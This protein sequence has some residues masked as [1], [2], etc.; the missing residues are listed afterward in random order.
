MYR[1]VDTFDEI[2]PC[3]SEFVKSWIFI[4][5]KNEFNEIEI[6]CKGKLS[7]QDLN[8]EDWVVCQMRSYKKYMQKWII[9]QI[10][11]WPGRFKDFKKYS[12]SQY[13]LRS[14]PK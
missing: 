11:N 9:H 3:F 7:V 8:A 13:K 2:P 10:R 14:L 5:Y 12:Q 1:F 4:C 6:L